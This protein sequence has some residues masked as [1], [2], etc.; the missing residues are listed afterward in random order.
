[1]ASTFDSLHPDN[2]ALVRK[3]LLAGWTM[4]DIR[5]DLPGIDTKTMRK[6]RDEVF[7]PL[8]TDPQAVKDLAN[9]P[10]L[11]ANTMTRLPYAQAVVRAQR[12]RAAAEALTEDDKDVIRQR[13]FGLEGATFGELARVF[14]VHH[15]TIK[16]ICKAA[17]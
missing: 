5:T 16:A 14:G 11:N 9:G 12:Q 2:A 7:V 15:N 8:V 4:K 1:M 17:E 6:L 3:R 10:L 13:H